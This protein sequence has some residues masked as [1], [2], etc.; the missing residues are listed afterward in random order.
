MSYDGGL[1]VKINNNKLGEVLDDFAA[2]G[3]FK[4]ESVQRWRN[5]PE[6]DSLGRVRK[7]KVK[8]TLSY[9]YMD[10]AYVEGRPKSL[11]EVGDYIIEL[12]SV[13]EEETI[14]YKQL[15]EIRERIKQKDVVNDYE[16]VSWKYF[17]PRSGE[18]DEFYYEK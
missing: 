11:D 6:E 5:K 16:L 3:Y 12:I 14:S 15:N 4:D 9:A 18:L 8:Y 2:K 10:C 7:P 17:A 13:Y 1:M